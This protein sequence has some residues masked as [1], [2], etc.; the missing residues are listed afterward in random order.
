MKMIIV[1]LGVLMA[2]TTTAAEA[3]ELILREQ[4]GN[5]FIYEWQQDGCLGCNYQ[6]LCL[7]WLP[8]LIPSPITIVAASPDEP[9]SSL[10]F[11]VE[12]PEGLL[13]LSRS[14]VPSNAI[15]V[16]AANDDSWDLVFSDCMEPTTEIELVTYQVMLMT[17]APIWICLSAPHQREPEWEL[18]DGS[19]VSGGRFPS[20]APPLLDGCIPVNPVFECPIP[21]HESSWSS[22]KARF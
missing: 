9:F 7:T 12:I 17:S 8:P 2:V 3:R 14:V 11:D 1:A 18:C 5:I 16:S 20:D 21:S 6:L 13:V 15:D 4:P 19:V 22:M 10:S